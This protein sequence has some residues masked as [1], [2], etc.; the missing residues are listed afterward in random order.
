MGF[1]PEEEDGHLGKIIIH[2][3]E[4]G[5]QSPDQTFYRPKQNFDPVEQHYP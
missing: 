5:D 3:G 4:S 1:L 2:I